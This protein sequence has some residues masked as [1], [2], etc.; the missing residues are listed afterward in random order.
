MNL[1]PRHSRWVVWLLPLVLIIPA[2]L[3]SQGFQ[4]QRLNN[5]PLYG[6]ASVLQDY[7]KD[8]DSLVKFCAVLKD[9]LDK[10]VTP[11]IPKHELPGPCWSF[12]VTDDIIDVSVFVHVTIVHVHR[13]D[14][15][16]AQA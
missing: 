16:S 10:R 13:K 9:M 2:T 12:I 5:G 14:Q 3:L 11:N 6:T 15:V 8:G 1:P 7:D 4:T